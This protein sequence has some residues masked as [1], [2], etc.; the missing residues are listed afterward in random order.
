MKK[1][2]IIFGVIALITTSY[3]EGLTPEQ[4]RIRDQEV[5]E[6]LAAFDASIA[7]NFARRDKEVKKAKEAG[8]SY[9]ETDAIE[10]K[11]AVVYR[12]IMRTRAFY[13]FKVYTE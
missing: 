7:D 11:Y 1:L 4:E 5:T 13:L 6:T 9:K 3:A 10:D 12:N 8:A 2:I